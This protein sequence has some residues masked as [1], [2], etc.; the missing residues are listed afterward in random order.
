MNCHDRYSP[1]VTLDD[2]MYLSGQLSLALSARRLDGAALLRL[3]LGKAS[4]PE[5]APLLDTILYL[6][7]GYGDRRRKIG[8]LAVLHPLRV[9]AILCRCMPEPTELD[10]LGAL[11]HDKEEDLTPEALGGA[12]W[13]QLQEEYRA[14]IS[15]I[16]SESQWLLGERVAILARRP[17]QSYDE[18]LSQIILR[19]RVMP[20]LLH[21]KLCDRWDNTADIV[22]QRDTMPGYNFLEAAFALMYLPDFEFPVIPDHSLPDKESCVVLLSA[23]YKNAWFMSLL[24]KA[25]LANLDDITSRLFYAVA[26]IS[27]VQAAWMAG[28]VL[29][30]SIPDND[31]RREILLDTMAYC[32]GGGIGAVTAPSRGH[33]LDGTILRFFAV[34][35][36]AE[37]HAQLGAIYDDKEFL[38]RLMV[39]FVAVFTSFITSSTYYIDGMPGARGR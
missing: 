7:H 3:I 34:S 35:D 31:T 16:D 6:L 39:T 24:R 14:L 11:L 32:A 33:P 12:R 1:Q 19:S 10:L 21:V 27:R 37:R 25:D 4:L 26:Y 2:F 28:E 30:L 38:C 22:V 18:Y 20:D 15:K 29:A 9:A 5:E 8:P 13:Q 36:D 17:G 23:L